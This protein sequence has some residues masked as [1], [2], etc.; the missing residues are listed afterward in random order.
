[1]GS[2]L[3]AERYRPRKYTE[4]VFK[5]DVHH[6]ALKWLKDYPEHGKILLLR[7]PSGTGKTSLAYVL[8]SAL[9]FDLVEFNADNDPDWMDRMLN[10]NRIINGRKNIILVDEI[11]GNPFLNVDKLISSPK[12]VCPLVMTS[13]EMCLK[14]VY[15]VEIQRPGFEEVRRGIEKICKEQGIS[16]ENSI[17]S[18]MASES[19]GDLRTIINHLQIH[20][21]R[22][23]SS[24]YLGIHKTNTISQ[25]KAAEL[26]LSRNIGWKAYEDIYSSSVL[27]LC[28]S[29]F[30]YNTNMMKCIADISEATSIADLLP[31]EFKYIALSKYGTC[32]NRKPNIQGIE[33]YNEPRSD[34]L[35]ETVLPFFKKYDLNRS[36]RRSLN[37]LKEIV[38]TYGIKDVKLKE[39]NLTEVGGSKA[40]KK[41]KFKYKSGCSVA[42]RRDVTMDDIM[43][44][45]FK[46]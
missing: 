40:S 9:G 36:D 8:S 15:T 18:Q 28:H 46:S 34:L 20:G 45:F 11:D 32:N 16:I 1:M 17:L 21:K 39:E 12:L 33:Y 41:F 10:S 43:D 13:N 42:F 14:D 29:S 37:H 26:I 7:G 31:E 19:G 30:P 27:S 25:H 44:W 4:L 3:W 2:Q 23:K 38:K 35:K 22:L 5:G 6:D 24:G